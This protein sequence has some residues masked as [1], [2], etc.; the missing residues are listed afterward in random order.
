MIR[1]LWA[2]ILYGF[3]FL[4]GFDPVNDWLI[5][6]LE[7]LEVTYIR[8]YNEL[9]ESHRQ[10]C[11][12]YESTIL[13]LRN[14]I[15][16]L[17]EKLDNSRRE[18]IHTLTPK[19]DLEEAAPAEYP[20]NLTRSGWSS[21]KNYLESVNSSAAHSERNKEIFSKIREREKE[22][23]EIIARE[24]ESDSFNGAEPNNS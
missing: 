22:V 6:T 1:L 14:E 13:E 17:Q 20:T 10:S 19:P 3:R 9:N 4:F 8:Y 11:S 15:K 5:K 16:I 24:S 23:E 2:R 12:I 7:R 18:L 21:Q